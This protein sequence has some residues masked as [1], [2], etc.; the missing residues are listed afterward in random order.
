VA[1]TASGSNLIANG[2]LSGVTNLTASGTVIFSNLNSTGIVHT[3]GSGQ[4]STSLVD[5]TTDVS[6]TLPTANGGSPFTEGNGAIFERIPS[7]D[8]LLGANSTGSAKFAI[9]NI[10][11]G[12]PT[13]TISAN[14]ANNAT[15]LTGAGVLGTS[16]KQTLQLGDSS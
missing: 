3:N 8:F 16:N 4:L 1:L 6:G 15:Y 2:T 7:Q 10:N 11:S 12:T 9:T 14:T 13:A 5:L